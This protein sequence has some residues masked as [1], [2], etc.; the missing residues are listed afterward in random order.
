MT[1]PQDL[2]SSG[3]VLNVCKRAIPV[4]VRFAVDGGVISTVEGPVEYMVNDAILTGVVGESWPVARKKFDARYEPLPGTVA[5]QAGNY[6]KRPLLVRATQL[7]APLTVAINRGLLQGKIGDWLVE[8]E[9]DDY[10]I[11]QKEIFEQTYDIL[12]S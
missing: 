10:G 2:F 7:V 5:G 11:V 9:H 6:K 4:A 3:K 1:K 12:Q 8:Y